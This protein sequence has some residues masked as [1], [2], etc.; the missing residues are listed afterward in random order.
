LSDGRYY[1]GRMSL[2]DRTALVTGASRGL[3]RAIAYRLAQD[4]AAVAI[5]YSQRQDGAASLASEIRN[6]G[7][8][9]MVCQ[10]DVANSVQVKDMVEKVMAE[11]GP[12]D[13]LV[14][15]AAV[16]HRADLQGHDQDQYEEMQR[17]NVGGIIHTTL[18]V[19]E[20]MKERRFG[21]IINMTSIAAHGTNLPGTT[22][23]A[24]TKAAVSLLTR[25]FALDLG[26]FGITVNAVAPG[27]VPTDMNAG[28]VGLVER[29]VE[30][31]IVG[32]AG[33]PEDIA[34]AVAFLASP[35]SGFIT[36]QTLTVDGG[37]MDY[38]AHP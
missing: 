16:F 4:G 11:L 6:A 13:I 2:A 8:R 1:L 7:G 38:I 29:V 15:N 10:A 25:R 34:H 17:V 36:A 14:N 33:K 21:R 19:V 23:Y 32:R 24:A 28:S 22:F 9:V 5:N 35:E 26:S 12:V 3:G 18:G 30:S 20:S 31:T 27:F 37:R